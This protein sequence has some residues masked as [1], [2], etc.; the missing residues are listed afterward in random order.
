MGRDRAETNNHPRRERK[1]MADT[2]NSEGRTGGISRKLLIPVA[3]SAVGTLLGYVLSKKDRLPEAASKLREAVSDLPVPET[4]GRTGELGNEL[5]GKLDKVL[6]K[7]Q[8]ADSDFA[9]GVP[10]K[11][12]L[13]EFEDRRRERQERRNQRRQ[14]SR[15]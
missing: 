5:R 6:G 4:P 3:I 11:Q 8:E 2:P 1:Q 9:S 14:R 15:S 10:T 13:S 7:E 12:D